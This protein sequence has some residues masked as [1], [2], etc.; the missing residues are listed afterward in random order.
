MK[1]SFGIAY[2]ELMENEDVENE[3]EIILDAV[4]ASLKEQFSAILER[5]YVFGCYLFGNSD[6]EAFS[7]GPVRFEPRH[8]WLARVHASRGLSRIAVSRIE[9]YGREKNFARENPPRMRFAN[10]KLL[11]L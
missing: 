9:R 6:I 1:R 8:N 4:I 7:F 5:E 3:G 2:V 10:A 11:M